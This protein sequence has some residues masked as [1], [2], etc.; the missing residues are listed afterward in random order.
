ME[1]APVVDINCDMGESFGVY[2]MG[3]DEEVVRYITSANVACGFHA[4]DPNCM[5]RTVKLCKEHE[6]MVGAHPGY[7]DVPGFGRRFMELSPEELVNYVLYQTGALKAFLDFYGLPLQHVKLHGA[8]YNYM[9]G[10][11]KAFLELAA[12]IEKAFEGVIFLTLGTGRTKDLKRAGQE[13]GLR[14]VLEAFPDRAYTD[15]GKLL[16]R[17]HDGAVLKDPEVIA[18]RAVTMVL[19]KGIESVNGRW[20][21]MEV[22][23]LCIHGDNE[24]SLAAARKTRELL[25]VERIGV[26]P[27]SRFI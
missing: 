25:E 18:R 26:A 10:H 23:T 24:E 15:E 6:V 8:F 9:S 20:V 27:L 12:S 17:R 11:E 13:L 5:D 16:D 3:C 4:S 19:Q 2:C 7:P 1:R 22:D 14:I 21:D